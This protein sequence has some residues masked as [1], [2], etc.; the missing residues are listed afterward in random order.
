MMVIGIFE[1]EREV[2]GKERRRWIQNDPTR[3][4]GILE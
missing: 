2:P 1:K 3:S 4:K